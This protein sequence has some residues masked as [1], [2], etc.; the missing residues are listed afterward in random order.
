[1]RTRVC[2]CRLGRATHWAKFT[3]TASIGVIHKGHRKESMKLLGSYLP[4]IGSTG[5]PYS[6][7]GA[8]YALGLIHANHGGE[9]AEYLLE[10][11]KNARDETIKHGACLGLGLSAMA[12]G[13]EDFLE[14]LMNGTHQRLYS[15]APVVLFWIAIRHFRHTSCLLLLA[16]TATLQ[17]DNAVAGEAAGYATGLIMVGFGQAKCISDMLTF[18]RNTKHEKLIRTFVFLLPFVL[19]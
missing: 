17:S 5:S 8:L 18:A 4:T 10:Q 9:H 2:A 16:C 19:F 12:T 11:I 1:M 6:E 7:G 15:S 13:R 3:A 14:T